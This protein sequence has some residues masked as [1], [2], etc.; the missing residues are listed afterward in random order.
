M[1][2]ASA[3]LTS[4]IT[5]ADAPAAPQVT[6]EVQPAAAPEGAA[7][8]TAQPGAELIGGKFK[9]T[10]DLLAAYKALESKL[11]AP[12]QDAPVVAPEDQPETP[13]A[14]A[15]QHAVT[16]AGLNF[17]NLAAEF[18]AEGDLKPESYEALAKAGI[19]KPM[20]NAYIAGQKALAEQ[21]A[22]QLYAV[23][24]GPD[25]F[26]KMTEWAGK[27]LS[28]AE[29]NAYNDAVT[30]GSI[31]QAKLAISGLN[32]RFAAAEGIR[33]NLVTGQ[34]NATQVGYASVQE[35]TRDMSDPRYISGDKAFHAMV[36]AKIL[37]KT[38]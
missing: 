33:P 12:K 22:Q 29:I 20:V 38:F 32:A 25:S 28:D 11:G 27:N 9:T 10:D 16:D 18:Q 19:P 2:Y 24:G 8:P 1:T 4:G 7:Q 37:N 14:D 17:D 34:T 21:H 13:A 31:D 36:D 26:A 15:A 35:M 23:A 30:K 3:T 5:G 6:P